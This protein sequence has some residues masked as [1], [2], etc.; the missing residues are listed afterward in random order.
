MRRERV[1]E[2]EKNTKLCLSITTM[3]LCV[4]SLA[5]HNILPKIEHA[6]SSVN[7]IKI[8][9]TYCRL[10]DSAAASPF[11]SFTIRLYEL[12]FLSLVGAFTTNSCKRW[13]MMAYTSSRF[14]DY[15]ETQIYRLFGS[16]CAK[17]VRCMRA[18]VTTHRDTM[19]TKWS[20]KQ[21]T[22][23]CNH[24]KLQTTIEC[25]DIDVMHA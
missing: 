18:S 16:L 1:R 25:K 20:D 8:I 19:H 14:N 9:S 12:I 15:I 2:R 7:D 5:L 4:I 3:Y 22:C 10:Y 23:K 13:M 6:T 17:C 24:P 21:K 11:F